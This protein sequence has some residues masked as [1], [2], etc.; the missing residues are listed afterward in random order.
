MNA[1]QGTPEWLVERAGHATASRAADILARIKVGEASV[2]RKYRIQLVTER[3]TGIP[4]QGYTNAAMLWGTQTE[5][6]AREAYE[7]QTGELVDQVGFIR[8]PQVM[9]CGA[10]PDGCLQ[11]DGLLELKCPESTTHLEWMDAERVPPEHIPQI[12]FQLWVTG[13]QWCDFVS[14]DPRFP[15]RLRLFIVRVKRDEKYIESLAAEVCNFLAEVDTMY[16]K[17]AGER[18]LVDDLVASLNPNAP[19]SQP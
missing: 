13:R 18:T 11:T 16:L 15:Q 6:E 12:M 19:A 10:S 9:W 14:Y 2:R 1:P 17:L 8:H 5:P 4:V 3:L 7:M